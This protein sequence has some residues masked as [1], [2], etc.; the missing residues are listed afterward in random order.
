MT[1]KK[2][3]V[4]IPFF[5]INLFWNV[6]SHLKFKDSQILISALGLADWKESLCRNDDKT[7]VSFPSLILSILSTRALI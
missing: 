2:Q 5:N 3:L 4:C 7:N 1:N 6:L